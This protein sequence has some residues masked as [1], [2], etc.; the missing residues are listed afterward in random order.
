MIDIAVKNCEN[1]ESARR[2]FEIVFEKKT[3]RGFSDL[4]AFRVSDRL[5]GASKLFGSS[6]FHLDENDGFAVARHD[7]DLG[8]VV[9]IVPREYFVARALEVF[10]RL[11][12][13]VR[14]VLQA[15]GFGLF[16]RHYH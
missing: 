15:R 9:T 6:R 14:A 5:F 1:V 3:L 2:V 16:P 13:T 10:G 4:S 7:V 12:F 11:I 8:A